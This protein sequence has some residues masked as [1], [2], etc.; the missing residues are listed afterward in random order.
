MYVANSQPKGGTDWATFFVDSDTQEWPEA[1]K[2][3]K[4]ISNFFFHKDG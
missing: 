3:E 4:K 2:I 1:K